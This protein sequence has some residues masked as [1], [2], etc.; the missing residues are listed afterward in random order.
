MLHIAGARSSVGWQR[1]I[2]YVAE[3]DGIVPAMECSGPHGWPLRPDVVLQSGS[4]AL[5]CWDG[6]DRHHR[7]GGAGA[8]DTLGDV[9]RQLRVSDDLVNRVDGADQRK[10]RFLELARVCQRD[11][12]ASGIDYR[13]LHVRG[14]D[15][16]FAELEI[17]D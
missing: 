16:G 12:S 15:A 6:L 10:R 1:P 2:S 17:A 11:D 14:L 3:L 5:L 4:T 7:Q 8:L 9:G 13:P